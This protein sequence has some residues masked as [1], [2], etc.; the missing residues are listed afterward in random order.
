MPGIPAIHASLGAAFIPPVKPCLGPL[1]LNLAESAFWGF[2]IFF[3]FTLTVTW[4]QVSGNPCLG[5]SG[6]LTPMWTSGGVALSVR[7]G[8]ASCQVDYS[9]TLS[10]SSGHRRKIS[11]KLCL[12]LPSLWK[13][14]SRAWHP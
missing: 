10:K 8:S 7:A 4:P 5:G 11:H 2:S 12:K 3:S 6:L 9:L 13:T 1:P 14:V